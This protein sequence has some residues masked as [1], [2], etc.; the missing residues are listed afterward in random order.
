MI[1]SRNSRA[2]TVSTFGISP[3]DSRGIIPSRTQPRK[4]FAPKASPQQCAF[5]APTRISS[6]HLQ[7]QLHR[8]R[9]RGL[10]VF[11]CGHNYRAPFQAIRSNQGKSGPPYSLQHYR[12][13]YFRDRGVRSTCAAKTRRA[14]DVAVAIARADGRTHDSRLAQ[15][16]ATHRTIEFYFE[17]SQRQHNQSFSA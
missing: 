17:G 15:S 8:R 13:V 16:V 2:A 1:G 3:S 14:G 9:S 4:C 7:I 6:S 10:V 11:T 5:G 12:F